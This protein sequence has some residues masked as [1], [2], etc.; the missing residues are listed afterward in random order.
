MYRNTLY[1]PVSKNVVLTN[2]NEWEWK[3]QDI[4]GQIKLEF[5]WKQISRFLHKLLS[6]LVI[7]KQFDLNKSSALYCFFTVFIHFQNI[8]AREHHST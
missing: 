2:G 4:L 5:T 1:S 8:H 3:S 7:T 6:N